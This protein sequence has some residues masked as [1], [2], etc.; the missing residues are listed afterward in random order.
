MHIA[1]PKSRSESSPDVRAAEP[2][3]GF[4]VAGFE[5]AHGYVGGYLISTARGRPVAFYYTRPIQPTQTHRILYGADLEPYVY[6]TL[7]G[8]GLIQQ[9]NS[10]PALILTDQIALLSIRPAV[11]APLVCCAVP[12]P[13]H[14]L[15]APS[16]PALSCHRDFQNDADVAR[17]WSAEFSGWSRLLEPLT[18]VREAIIEVISH[19]QI[20]VAA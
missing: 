20:P 3:L 13:G 17:R 9:S 16:D 15:A 14:E 4:L 18:R 2:F 11:V 6:G 10:T 5:P 12:T 19:E 8:P 1:L 7:V